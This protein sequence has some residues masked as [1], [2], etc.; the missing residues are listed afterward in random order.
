MPSSPTSIFPS[1]LFRRRRRAGLVTIFSLLLLLVLEPCHHAQTSYPI[2]DPPE[3]LDAPFFKT[4][5][6][7]AV[8]ADNTPRE[9]AVLF[10]LARNSE[11]YAAAKTV[12]NLEA[13]FNQHFNY[14]WVFLNDQPFEKAFKNKV[15]AALSPGTNVTFASITPDMWGWP[16][17]FGPKQQTKAMETWDRYAHGMSQSFVEGTHV[18]KASYHHMCRFNSGFFYDHPALKPYKW[19]W[20]VEPGVSFS[21]DV[22]YDPFHEM[23]ER[24][25]SYGYTVALW[26]VGALSPGLFRATADWKEKMRLPDRGMWNAMIEASWAPW[27]LRR[28]VL[29]FWPSKDRFGDGWS[30]CHFWSNFEIAD[31]DM[32]RSEA[33]GDYFQYLDDIGGFHSERWGDAPVHSLA[34]AMFL[35][36]EQIHYFQD[37]GYKHPPFQHCPDKDGLGCNCMCDDSKPANGYCLKAL[38]R[39]VMPKAEHRKVFGD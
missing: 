39:P 12:R 28:M 35:E 9:S 17:H 27:P 3:S 29:P 22:T 5:Q 30:M 33:Y 20:R 8:Y 19:Y 16:D 26:E 13:K 4:C 38:R 36:A 23:A 21:C 10:M 24:N 6:D 1:R 37:I 32:F 15:S 31:L 18:Q 11:A 14:P 34:A 2:P 25:K 7:A